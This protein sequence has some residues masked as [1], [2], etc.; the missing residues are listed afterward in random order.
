MTRPRR[1]A[2]YLPGA[3]PR[4]LEKA[5]SLPADVLVLDLE[6]AVAPDAK[7]AA[8]QRV[9]Q[10]VAE[11][12]Y[13]S[14]EV[15]VR[16]NAPGTPWYADDLAAVAAVGPDAVLV[17]KVSDPQTVHAID[18]DL[19][20]TAAPTA[21]KIW[22]MLETPAAVLAAAAVAAATDRLEVL[23]LGTNDLAN[24]LHAEHL[25]GRA[26]LLAGIGM[27]VLGARAAGKVVLD[28]VYNDV[29]DPAGFEAECLQGRQF[30][31]DG[32][33]LIHPDQ[34]EPCNRVFSPTPEQIA[35]SRAVVAAW[36]EAV[37]AGR[38]VA[39]VEGRLIEH[40]HVRNARRI[41]DLAQLLD[42]C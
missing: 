25:P 15:V 19:R 8:R 27:A 23:V 9:C 33:T 1:S 32:K 4:A 21:P 34:V 16:V 14:R 36:D 41:L 7:P 11:R 2:L 39:T 5:R 17:P 30:G 13:G 35:H 38:A 42:R 10:Q 12:V 28:G 22:A 6:D 40:L 3:N 20:A 29:R 37:A 24:E 18:R 31:F 26:P